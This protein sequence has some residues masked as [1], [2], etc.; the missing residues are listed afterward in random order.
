MRKKKVNYKIIS[1]YDD[2]KRFK[3][4]YLKDEFGQIDCQVQ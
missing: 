1:T 3:F 2:L 4:D